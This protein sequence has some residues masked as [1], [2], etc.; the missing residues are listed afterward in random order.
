MNPG[1]WGLK[2]FFSWAF[3]F[4]LFRART[5]ATSQRP[6]V[7]AIMGNS[8][9]SAIE[10]FFEEEFT[11]G[12]RSLTLYRKGD[13]PGV[14]LLHELPGLTHE[15]AEFGEWIA[16]R[17]FH[18]VMP[19]MFGRPLQHSALGL[20]KFPFVCIR[21]EF[22]NIVAGKSSPITI[23]LR[24]LCRKIHTERGGPGVGAIGMCYTGG[25]VFALMV[26]AAVLAPVAA[27]PSLP[28]FDGEALDVEPEKLVLAS[29]R[30]DTMSLLGL[31]FKDDFRCP[32]ARFEHLE[33]ALKSPPDL[34][35]QR[36]HSIVVPGSGHSTLTSDYQK[37]L[38]QGVDTRELVLK[39]L[40]TQLLG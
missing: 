40:R 4:V 18:V 39:H 8:T 38:D 6:S 35:T 16:D 33:T 23:A 30:P 15:T 2:L 29:N 10:G 11:S 37:A 31:R 36:F 27:Q 9:N 7:G 14:I 13:G 12:D 26:E 1:A 25:F 21:K 34:A 28:F 20:L 24:A 22:N 17:G 5:I 19:L 3:A 32:A